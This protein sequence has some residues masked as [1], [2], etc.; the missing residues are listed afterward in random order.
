MQSAT[1]IKR[2]AR[3]AGLLDLAMS[4]LAMLPLYFGE[5]IVVLWLA[6]IGAKPRSAEVQ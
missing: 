4:I 3:E 5:F 2:A 1:E 6:I